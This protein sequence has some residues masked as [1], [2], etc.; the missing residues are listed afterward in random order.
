M[1]TTLAYFYQRISFH[2]ETF[3]SR[4]SNDSR[5]AIGSSVRAI[6]RPRDF[7]YAYAGR[8]TVMPFPS[9]NALN[10]AYTNADSANPPTKKIN[11]EVSRGDLGS[12]K[13]GV[14]TLIL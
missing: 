6:D 10:F 3:D 4:A 13:K 12:S 8:T 1:S 2:L 14:F 11:Y 7:T 5:P 9:P